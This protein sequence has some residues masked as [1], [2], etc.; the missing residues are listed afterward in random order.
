M[1]IAYRPPLVVLLK[2]GNIEMKRMKTELINIISESEDGRLIRYIYFIIS[3]YRK[4]LEEK[5]IK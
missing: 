4:A 5:A 3:G 2:G 1:I